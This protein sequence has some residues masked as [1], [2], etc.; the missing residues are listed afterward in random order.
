MLRKKLQGFT[1]IEVLVSMVI[2]SIGVLAL[3]M[4]QISSLQ[5]TQGGY[6]RS[7]ATI[8]AYDIIDSMRANIPSVTAG[9][10]RIAMGAET[11]VAVAC[12]GVIANCTTQQIALSDLTRWRTVLLN[13]LPNGGGA[14][15]TADIGGITQVTV[16][17]QWIDPYSAAD[18]NEQLI[19]ASQLPQ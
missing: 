10:Y 4:L 7:Q 15:T 1:I 14:V 2:L 6:Q 11:P 19:L 8:L 3:G 17:V 12:D 18:G 13:H 16:S 5:N 9:D